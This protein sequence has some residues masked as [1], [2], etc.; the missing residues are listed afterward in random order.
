MLK[1]KVMFPKIILKKGKEKSLARRHPWVFSGAISRIDNPVREGDVV[2]V[3]DFN[4]VYLATGHYQPSSI[5]VRIFSFVRTEANGQFW[6]EKFQEAFS[7]RYRLGITGY[8]DVF[9]LVNAEGDGMPGLIV[10]YY[11][12]IFVMQAHSAGMYFNAELF[13]DI[14]VELFER[15]LDDKKTTGQKNPGI[16]L[17]KSV[18]NKSSDTLPFKAGIEAQNGFIYGSPPEHNNIIVS[19]YGYK[20]LVDIEG[21]QK[22]GFFIDQRENRKLLERF[23][24]GKK[25]LNAFSY[26]GGFTVY[27]I[28]GDAS[29]VHSVDSSAG[30][31][32]LAGKNLALNFGSIFRHESFCEDVF[33][34]L[35]ATSDTYDVI[36]LDPPAFSKHIDTLKQGLRGYERLNEMALKKISRGGILF[37][38]SCS[39]SVSKDAFRTTLFRSSL[40]VKR[41]LKIIYQL[42]Q[43][44]DHPVSIYHPEGEYLKG[45][46]L[47]V[48]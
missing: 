28:G 22:T 45:L 47:K 20:F 1:S 24:T 16:I 39:Q 15:D 19:E 38:F 30:S 25:V 9:R 21:G 18:Y 44:G 6:K 32:D 31:L 2:E 27:A 8:C 48:E 29:V 36:I 33:K 10:D 34:F 40:A 3:Y 7:L 42:S 12:G 11:N 46:V 43:P 23:C 17:L 35:A 4:G 37:T 13:R 14:L 41:D 26:T 5:S